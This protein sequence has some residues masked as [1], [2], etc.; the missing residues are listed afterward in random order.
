MSS[1]DK[2]SF[3]EYIGN[4]SA[5]L[6]LDIDAFNN[7]DII[8]DSDFISEATIREYVKGLNE[9]YSWNLITISISPDYSGGATGAS[10]LL[11]IV[12][13]ELEIGLTDMEKW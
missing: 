12:L 2:K 7:S 6:D 8:G 10:Y 5:I 3:A 13:S 9:L 4:R 1:Y 11:D